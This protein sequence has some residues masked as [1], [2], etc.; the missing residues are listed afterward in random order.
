MEGGV[1][2]EKPLLRLLEVYPAAAKEPFHGLQPLLI[3]AEAFLPLSFL[4]KLLQ[5]YPDIVQASSPSRVLGK[6]RRDEP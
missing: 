6:R 1:L 2:D 5:C 4:F 3:A